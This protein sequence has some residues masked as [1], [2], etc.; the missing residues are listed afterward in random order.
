MVDFLLEMAPYPF[1]GTLTQRIDGPASYAFAAHNT[2]CP[3]LVADLPTSVCVDRY[4]AL[5]FRA[6]C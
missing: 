2:I 5:R 3:P 6:K 1:S 4:G